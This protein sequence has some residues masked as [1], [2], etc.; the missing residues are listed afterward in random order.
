MTRHEQQYRNN[1]TQAENHSFPLTERTVLFSSVIFFPEQLG[2]YEN[3]SRNLLSIHL[4]RSAVPL[5]VNR[6]KERTSLGEPLAREIRLFDERRD[7]GE[8][9]LRTFE[10]QVLPGATRQS[11]ESLGWHESA[12]VAPYANPT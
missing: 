11:T 8:S 5:S 2:S 9:R 3:G 7:A 4:G 6:T 1:V 10:I 12:V